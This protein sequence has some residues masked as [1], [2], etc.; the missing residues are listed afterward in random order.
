MRITVAA[1]K[2]GDH[3]TWEWADD[4]IRGTVVWVLTKD[5]EFKGVYET[6]SYS[7]VYRS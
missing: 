1:F 4:H 6:Y 5:T 3:V 2:V 7:R